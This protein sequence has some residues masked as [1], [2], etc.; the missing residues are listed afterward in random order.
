MSFL[1]CRALFIL[2][3]RRKVQLFPQRY[4]KY[5]V[6]TGGDWQRRLM[7]ALCPPPPGEE[8][9]SDDPSK[10]MAYY[11]ERAGA[12]D[13]GSDP[14]WG[15][16][17]YTE[18]YL[19]GDDYR[20]RIEYGTYGCECPDDYCDYNPWHR[21]GDGA[22]HPDL[23]D[24]EGPGCKFCIENGWGYHLLYWIDRSTY[25][26]NCRYCDDEGCHAC[27]E[28]WYLLVEYSGAEHGF[29]Q[30]DQEELL[31]DLDYDDSRDGY[32]LLRD[33][34]RCSMP[35]RRGEHS[36][37]CRDCQDFRARVGSPPRGCIKDGLPQSLWRQR[38][39]D[40][41]E[42]ELKRWVIIGAM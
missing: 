42:L 22:Y 8:P 38:E 24:C 26:R 25:L 20:A 12:V 29:F 37:A 2:T 31:L 34:R 39:D 41:E 13:E 9:I 4:S 27:D 5:E 35:L 21:G 7:D 6:N 11:A 19:D 32:D 15:E 17:F 33:C 3:E 36:G 16:P 30:D 28:Y 14:E 1:V 23:T 40:Y 18:D 10:L